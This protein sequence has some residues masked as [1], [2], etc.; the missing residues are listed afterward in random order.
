MILNSL[1]LFMSLFMG[2]NNILPLFSVIK[3]GNEPKAVVMDDLV[4][5]VAFDL[6]SD[7]LKM[8][9]AWINPKKNQIVKV[10]VT[11]SLNLPLQEAINR[12]PNSEIPQ[13]M[14]QQLKA[15]LLGMQERAQLDGNVTTFVGGATMAYRSAPNGNEVL[16]KLSKELGI[17]M[18]LLTPNEEAM[19]GY[20]SLEAEGLVSKGALVWENG[21][22]STQISHI[23]KG[24]FEAYNLPVDKAAIIQEIQKRGSSS[25]PNPLG[26]EDAAAGIQWT[27]AQFQDA[28]DWVRKKKTVL[29]IG[30]MFPNAV[31]GLGKSTFTK[32]DLRQL[33]DQKLDKADQELSAEQDPNTLYML[34]DLLFLYGVMEELEIEEV[35]CPKLQGPGSTSALLLA[36]LIS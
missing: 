13:E 6:G 20:S 12:D 17:S 2:L 28:P 7:D 32:S 8:Q 25:P 27:Q 15:A 24:E 35:E 16:D 21:R 36:D 18:F 14:V 22:G 34:S 29:G 26:K 30:A 11:E 33:I 1:F 3:A 19:L 23:A 10:A 31:K 5:R 4:Y 9:A